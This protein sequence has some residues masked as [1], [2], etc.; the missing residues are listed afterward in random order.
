MS[1]S[2]LTPGVTL[3]KIRMKHGMLDQLLLLRA[4]DFI[5]WLWIMFACVISNFEIISFVLFLW[6]PMLLK[7]HM[8][9]WIYVLWT[10][11]ELPEAQVGSCFRSWTFHFVLW[12]IYYIYNCICI[13]KIWWHVKWLWAQ[14]WLR[15]QFDH[16]I[17]TQ[18]KH[19]LPFS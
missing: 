18:G 3:Q 5:S 17:W 14:W 8:Q 15:P 19:D 9:F 10:S 4:I 7:H 13:V 11:W 6:Q 1:L 16:D 12:L 2:Y